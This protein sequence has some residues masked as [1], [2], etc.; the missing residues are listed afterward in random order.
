VNFVTGG[1]GLVGSHILLELAKKG[2]PIVALKRASTD[3]SVVKE[4]FI[5][6]N[7]HSEFNNIKWVAGSLSD[8]N[9]LVEHLEN[10]E[11]IYHAAA[12][13]SFDSSDRSEL[14]ET[15]IEGTSN[16]VD[17]ALV[18]K[19]KKFIYI[20]S[21]SAIG[22]QPKTKVINE[23][24]E[25]DPDNK[26]GSYSFSKHYAEREV[27][28][29]IEEGLNTVILN[30]AVVLGPG[31]WGTSSTRMFSTVYNGLQFYTKGGN[32]FVD[33]RDVAQIAIKLAESSI[34]SER[35]LVFS[36]NRSFREIMNLIAKGLNKSP[37][38]YLAT[39]FMG[40]LAGLTAEMWAIISG[41]SPLITRDSSRSA[42]S[43]QQYS[44]RKLLSAIE[45]DFIPIEKC[46]AD[47]C[48]VFLKAQK[49]N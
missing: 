15:N 28:R 1:S 11:R 45:H 6:N 2:E 22:K 8:I 13:V 24:N 33:V 10:C 25:W 46:I 30:P 47:T 14:I 41:S 35:F 48:E 19:P 7:L 34:S 16:L 39:P 49:I 18:I 44:N 23:S 42:N 27:W 17:A 38:K 3:L 40:Y 29:G 5:R 12:L 9:V 20:S 43:T 36:E 4:L 32:A 21:T 26:N 31:K 37:A